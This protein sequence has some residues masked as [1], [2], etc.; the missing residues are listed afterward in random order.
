MQNSASKNTYDQENTELHVEFYAIQPC[1]MQLLL[2][3]LAQH[4]PKLCN[5]LWYCD[6]NKHRRPG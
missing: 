5:G 2:I 3:R 1:Q 4:E 6:Q